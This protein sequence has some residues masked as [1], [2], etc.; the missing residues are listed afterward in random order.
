MH[1]PRPVDSV[2]VLPEHG[3][4]VIVGA[5]AYIVKQREEG[6]RAEDEARDSIIAKSTIQQVTPCKSDQILKYVLRGGKDLSVLREHTEV[7]WSAG[8]IDDQRK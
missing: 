2:P 7:L 8:V 6:L 1:I 5:A 4:L 3:V